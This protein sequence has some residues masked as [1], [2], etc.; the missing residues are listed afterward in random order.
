MSATQLWDAGYRDLV[1]VTPP[2]CDLSPGSNIDLGQCGKAPGKKRRDGWGG[3]S[4]TKELPETEAEVE[5]WQGWGANV[6]LLGNNYPGLDV[7]SSSKTFVNVV[8]SIADRV[9]GG[10]P[11]RTGRLPRVLRVYATRAPFP[12]MALHA[13]YNGE[14]NTVEVLGQGRQYVVAG[15]H[16]SGVPYEWDVNLWDVQPGQLNQINAKLVKL[17]FQE[18]RAFFE[19][20][21]VVIE[22]EGD[23]E[24]REQK[25]PPQP[26]LFAPSVDDLRKVVRAI[27]NT[28]EL[29]PERDDY[30]LFGHALK[31]AGTPWPADALDLWHEWCSRWEG[32]AR[33][34]SGN[35]PAVVERDWNRMHAPFRVGWSWLVEQAK[36]TAEEG[37]T[38]PVDEFE[39]DLSPPSPPTPP[40]EE[41]AEP[42]RPPAK[43]RTLRFASDIVENP[44]PPQRW[45]V[46]R[47]LPRDSYAILFAPPGTGKSWLSADLALAVASGG[48]FLG[49]DV[50]GSAPVFV[51]APDTS[52]HDVD[53]MLRR[54]A[55]G[56]GVDLREVGRR[57]G[58][59]CDPDL[60][61][62][63][64]GGLS[65]LVRL[66]RESFDKPPA[67]IVID[68]LRASADIDE[69]NSKEAARFNAA[70]RSLMR[71]FPQASVLVLHHTRKVVQG[72][73][74]DKDP[75]LR[76]SSAF[77]AACDLLW[78]L[79][80]L[81]ADNAIEADLGVLTE[82]YTELFCPRMRGQKFGRRTVRI[83]YNT[84]EASVEA[85]E[86][87]HAANLR[88]E[89]E[90]KHFE[91]QTAKKAA[92]ILEA[93]EPGRLYGL[94][95]VAK[96]AHVDNKR[97]GDL[98]NHMVR[99]GQLTTEQ[100]GQWTKYKLPEDEEPEEE[101][102]EAPDLT[103]LTEGTA[104]AETSDGGC[105]SAGL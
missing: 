32:N 81:G 1:C 21:G 53:G 36:Q 43:K 72:P 98:L 20:K 64:K 9:L 102:A 96:A 5:T 84:D 17:F 57:I 69:N 31:A 91:A 46:D 13:T 45:V 65:D 41:P 34:P 18:I 8:L 103:D 47:L 27:P 35:D 77:E 61:P 39:P 92:K 74:K 94:N 3:Y 26:D 101:S 100:P 2:G 73:G 22:I 88:D 33:N 99:T 19:P 87:E 56:R 85:L 38:A 105:S 7:D 15:T 59:L 68:S 75:V 49:H 48:K 16:P 55:S 25:A 54:L 6:G 30:I 23:G 14:K 79:R 80:P 63:T 52:L 70:V 97:L 4:F 78:A 66:A 93:L 12:R 83:T 29:F 82:H 51:W 95:E 62:T 42:E 71:A 24:T 10:G 86:K 104:A 40:P 89:L 44:L 50:E 90:R 67:L 60:D 28:S 76:G 58:F 11:T 37:Y